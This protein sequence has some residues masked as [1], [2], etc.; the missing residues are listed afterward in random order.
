MVKWTTKISD[1]KNKLYENIGI[2]SENQRLYFK[3]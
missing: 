2:E 1:L 3:D